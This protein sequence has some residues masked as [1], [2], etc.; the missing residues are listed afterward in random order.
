MRKARVSNAV[1]LEQYQ[2]WQIKVQRD[3]ERRT[4]YSSTRGIAGMREANAKADAWLNNRINGGS[5]KVN[6][7]VKKWLAFEETRKGESS[8]SQVQKVSFARKY[9]SPMIGNKAVGKV[10]EGDL[11]RIINVIANNGATKATLRT[12]RSTISCFVEYCNK[13]RFCDLDMQKVEVPDAAMPNRRSLTPNEIKILFTSSKTSCGKEEVEDYY[14]HL[15]RFLSLTGLR[16]GELRARNK[17]DVVN[18]TLIVDSAINPLNEITSGKT[19]QAKRIITLPQLALQELESQRIAER[20]L[21]ISSTLLFPSKSGKYMPMGTIQDAWKRYCAHNGIQY[22]TV[23]ELSR[24]TFYT[25]CEEA[26]VS[27]PILKRVFG[28]SDSMKSSKTYGHT[29]DKERATV[30][31]AIDASFGN[32]IAK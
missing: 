12:Y 17:S 3:G 4:F 31:N 1:W 18:G 28:H 6:L 13:D 8:M 22:L 24:H 30:A 15:F 2:R 5:T 10:T 7:L 11:Q 20:E 26:E 19:K 32:I 21:G 16:P 29:T 25:C 14:V 27:E 9:I 23:Y